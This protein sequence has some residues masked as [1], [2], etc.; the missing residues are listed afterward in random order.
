VLNM[1]DRRTLVTADMRAV[2][3]RHAPVATTEVVRRVAHVEAAVAHLPVTHYAPG[4]P[5]AAEMRALAT[6]VVGR[7]KG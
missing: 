1:A 7:L 5:A 3:A 6:E 2:A 4:S